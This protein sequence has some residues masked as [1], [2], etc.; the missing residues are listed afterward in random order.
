MS[1]LTVDETLERIQAGKAWDVYADPAYGDDVEA[2]TIARCPVAACD[3]LLHLAGKNGRL[4]TGAALDARRRQAKA[5]RAEV[6][7][8]VSASV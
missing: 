3:F 5:H 1:L 2:A 7:G 8:H 6:H 4:L